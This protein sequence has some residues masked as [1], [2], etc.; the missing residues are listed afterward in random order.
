[1]D[2][3]LMKNI[4]TFTQSDWFID[5]LMWRVASGQPLILPMTAHAKPHI[6][7]SEEEHCPTQRPQ[8][9]VF[10]TTYQPSLTTAEV[11]ARVITPPT[12]T[13]SETIQ[14]KNLN[15]DESVE[16]TVITEGVTTLA[17]HRQGAINIGNKT[18]GCERCPFSKNQ[19]ST[20]LE[21]KPIVSKS[22][23]IRQTTLAN[24]RSWPCLSLW[25]IS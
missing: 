6:N 23:K 18:V 16:Q 8:Q 11:E 12:R 2:A 5:A 20:H 22:R 1:M 24:R 9:Q 17:P 7:K 3:Q 19:E 10:E 15:E 14:M 4:E 25:T 21:L 13:P